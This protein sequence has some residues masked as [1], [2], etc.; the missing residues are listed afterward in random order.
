MKH[1]CN[2]TSVIEKIC[3]SSAVSAPASKLCSKTTSHPLLLAQDF[4]S[5][6]Q[7]VFLPCLEDAAKLLTT[8]LRHACLLKNVKYPGSQI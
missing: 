5:V 1:F 6:K 8:V 4:A 2:K 3:L 7:S